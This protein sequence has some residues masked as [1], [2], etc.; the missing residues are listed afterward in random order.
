MFQSALRSEERSDFYAVGAHAALGCFN[1]RFAPKSEAIWRSASTAAEISFQSALRSEERSDPPCGR[2]DGLRIW[3]SI[4]A[5]LR[6]AKRCTNYYL[7]GGDDAFQSALRSEERS[8]GSARVHRGARR[9]F[10]PRFAPKSEAISAVTLSQVCFFEFQ[11]ALRSEERSDF[12]HDAL[13]TGNPV[14]IRA[15]LRRAKR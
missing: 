10:N 3:V 13:S 5:S 11:S 1:P 2:N 14:S 7:V 8:D 12:F 6:R 15:S 9:R 4:R